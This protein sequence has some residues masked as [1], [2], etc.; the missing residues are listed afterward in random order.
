VRQPSLRARLPLRIFWLASIVVLSAQVATRPLRAAAWQ[1]APPATAQPTTQP[2]GDSEKEVNKDDEQGENAYRHSP[3]IKAAARILHLSSE[4][5]AR[6]FE[7]LNFAVVFFGI[8]I[9]L[10][11]FLPRY[12]RN[13]SEKVA[14]DID[15]ARKKT[16]DANQRLSAVEAKLAHLDDE[17]ARFR[18]EM[19]VEMRSDEARIKAS[20]EEEGARIVAG[21]EQEIG[22]AAAQARRGLKHFAAGLAIEKAAREL[23]L[24]AET[25]K[26]LIAEFVADAAKSANGGGVR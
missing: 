26:A 25:D 8:G 9:P 10:Y 19:E 6:S 12:L 1:D 2:A 23:V 18:A 22:V 14:S 24:T 16:D 11:R 17:I 3:M 21:A 4:T 7:I 20:I 15:S 5:T 13:R